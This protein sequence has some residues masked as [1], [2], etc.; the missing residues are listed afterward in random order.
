MDSARAVIDGTAQ[1]LKLL[2]WTSG[3]LG[4]VSV[5][6]DIELFLQQQGWQADIGHDIRPLDIQTNPRYEDWIHRFIINAWHPQREPWRLRWQVRYDLFNQRTG[7][8]LVRI[9]EESIEKF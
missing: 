5:W 9:V 6:R 7:L 8:P 1:Y 2:S 4:D 3:N